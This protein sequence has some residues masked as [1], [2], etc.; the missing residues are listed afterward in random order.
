[1]QLEHPTPGK[2][3]QPC[4]FQMGSQEEN[5]QFGCI[6]MWLE[7]RAGQLQ[8]RGMYTM[9]V[10]HHRPTGTPPPHPP[11]PPHAQAHQGQGDR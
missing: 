7:Q 8:D 6:W 2:E 10:D 3:N 1:M 4:P 5:G 11:P 9:T